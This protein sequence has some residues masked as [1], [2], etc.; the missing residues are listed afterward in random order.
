MLKDDICCWGKSSPFHQLSCDVPLQTWWSR[1]MA[2]RWVHMDHQVNNRVNQLGQV[3]WLSRW[4]SLPPSILAWVGS[5]EP[6]G[7]GQMQISQTV[8]WLLHVCPGKTIP[9]SSL[10][11]RHKI[12]CLVYV[13]DGMELTL[14]TEIM[15]LQCYST[16]RQKG[17]LCS[18]KQT[19][20]WLFS[21]ENN[22]C[23]E[24]RTTWR[25]RVYKDT[26]YTYTKI[27]SC[28]VESIS[29]EKKGKLI[30]F[31]CVIISHSLST[32]QVL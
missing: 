26:Q 12:Q 31:A 27:P 22:I 11:I 25:S 6:T 4:K 29:T 14:P 15:P 1:D 16:V 24:S 7:E 23:L 21:W 18:S 28:H 30:S 19:R 13:V 17:D 3:R 2:L 5:P 32:N 9:N 10:L 20:F 8:L